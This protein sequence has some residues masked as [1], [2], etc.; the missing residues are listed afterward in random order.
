MDI[1][2]LAQSLISN[3]GY[4]AVVAG[5]MA[6]GKTRDVVELFSS[7][8]RRAI[9]AQMIKPSMDY[10]DMHKDKDLDEHCSVSRSGGYWRG[11]AVDAKDPKSIL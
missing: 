11:Q 10:R 9:P 8:E 4:L 3:R 2:Q 6:S 5:N 7:L 1:D